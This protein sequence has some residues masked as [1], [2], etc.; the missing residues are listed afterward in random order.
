M[1]SRDEPPAGRANRDSVGAVPWLAGAKQFKSG[2]HV[3]DDDLA[4]LHLGTRTL[5]RAGHQTTTVGGKGQAEHVVQTVAERVDGSS[6][7]RLED[8]E[9]GSPSFF[10]GH[11][12]SGR[13]QV[14]VWAP[15]QTGS[16]PVQDR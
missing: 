9:F 11:R 4:V 16:Q 2:G 5:P 1:P 12:R 7:R 14:T 6:R 8:V 13:D 15:R 10:T 3:P